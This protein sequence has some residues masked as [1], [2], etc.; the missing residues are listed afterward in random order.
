[1]TFTTS[2]VFVTALATRFALRNMGDAV[3]ITRMAQTGENPDG[4]IVGIPESTVYEGKAR[5]P[6]VTG[7]VT[8]QLGEEPQYFSS[9]YVSVPVLDPVSG[10]PVLPMVD[11]VVSVTAHPDQLM[12]GRKFRVMDVETGGQFGPVRRMQLTGIQPSKQWTDSAL[13]P[14]IPPEWLP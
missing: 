8:Y 9:T 12:V 13:H 14:S 5:F 1:M 10:Q 7:P 4:T 6:N 3:L 11:D 2:R